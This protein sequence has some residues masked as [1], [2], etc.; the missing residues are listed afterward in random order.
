MGN[1]QKFSRTA[2][3]FSIHPKFG[4]QAAPSLDCLGPGVVRP[5]C[6]T[7]VE[8]VQLLRQVKRR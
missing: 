5:L 7:T 1:E 6:T 3:H 4:H 8:S 2:V